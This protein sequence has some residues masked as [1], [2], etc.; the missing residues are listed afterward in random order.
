[1]PRDGQFERGNLAR[2]SDRNPVDRVY[3]RQKD[4]FRGVS[5]VTWYGPMLQLGR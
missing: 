2:Y 4:N 3:C 5:E 1:M